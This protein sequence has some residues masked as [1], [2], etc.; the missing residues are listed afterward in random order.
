MLAATGILT[1]KLG[2]EGKME[3]DI[4]IERVW[5]WKLVWNLVYALSKLEFLFG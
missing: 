4:D 3:E 1:A 5:W 2:Y